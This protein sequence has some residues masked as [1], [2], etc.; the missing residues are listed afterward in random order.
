MLTG[1]AFSNRSKT[2][3]NGLKGRTPDHHQAGACVVETADSETT[4]NR[5]RWD[6]G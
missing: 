2:R 1:V 4:L 3:G 5:T 6:E